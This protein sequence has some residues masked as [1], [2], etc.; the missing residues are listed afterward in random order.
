METE[1]QY[2]NDEG[3]KYLIANNEKTIEELKKVVEA[4]R[5]ELS[6]RETNVDK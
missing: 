1:L 2:L 3:I 5:D 6:R 4:L